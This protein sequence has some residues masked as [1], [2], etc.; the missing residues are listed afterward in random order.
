MIFLPQKRSLD[1]YHYSLISNSIVFFLI[2]SFSDTLVQLLARAKTDLAHKT[3]ANEDLTI[4]NRSLERQVML[5]LLLLPSYLTQPN[6]T[7]THPAQPSLIRTYPIPTDIDLSFAMYY[8][9]PHPYP[10]LTACGTQG[11]KRGVS[12]PYRRYER[13]ARDG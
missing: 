11:T 13:Q 3:M 10:T 1:L 5:Y 9:L 7:L 4:Y 2:H 8:T 6:L 12:G